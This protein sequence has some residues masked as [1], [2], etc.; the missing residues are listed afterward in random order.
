MSSHQKNSFRSQISLDID[1]GAPS[2]SVVSDNR[3]NSLPP[4]PLRKVFEVIF[5]LT[6]FVLACASDTRGRIQID[7]QVLFG[8]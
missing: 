6:R 3:E 4:S 8:F 1:N 5:C 2:F 7:R